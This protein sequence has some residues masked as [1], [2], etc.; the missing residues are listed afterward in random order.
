MEIA[1]TAKVGP[2]DVFNPYLLPLA[3][4]FASDFFFSIL[5]NI[6]SDNMPVFFL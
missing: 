1:Y 4:F 5:S 2:F 6:F 3:D